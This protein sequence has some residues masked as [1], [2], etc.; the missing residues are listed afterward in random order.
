MK[1]I[2]RGVALWQ[3]SIMTLL[4]YLADQQML[5]SALALR[6]RVPPSTVHRW[7]HGQRRPTIGS[8]IKIEK[9]TGGAVKV[10]DFYPAEAA[11]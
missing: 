7:L 2:D 11:E 4:E 5:P 3:K 6:L 8:L 9:A 1:F 10:K